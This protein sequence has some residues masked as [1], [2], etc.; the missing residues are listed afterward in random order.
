MMIALKDIQ[1]SDRD[2]ARILPVLTRPWVEV[3]AATVATPRNKAGIEELLKWLKLE[4]NEG[5]RRD[6][7]I[8]RLYRKAAD[9]RRE[10]EESE[11]YASREYRSN[12]SIRRVRRTH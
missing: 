12:R 3:H 4:I 11:L 7:V 1:V 8:H 2:R 9:I 6:F 10:L 5:P